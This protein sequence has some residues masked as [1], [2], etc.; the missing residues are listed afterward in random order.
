MAL[1]GRLIINHE[2][3]SQFTLHGVGTFPAYSGSGEF[4]NQTGCVD[5]PKAGPLPPGRYHIV[6][7]PT[8]GWKGVSEGCIT[9][10]NRTDFLQVRQSLLAT[11]PVTLRNGL[12]SYG[13]IEVIANGSKACPGRL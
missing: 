6:D 2:L 7:R 1:E 11:S 8:G 9:F 12:R 4:R 13:T 3:V 5:V 10:V